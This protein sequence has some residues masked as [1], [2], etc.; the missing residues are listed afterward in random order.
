M[1][2]KIPPDAIP[3]YA[4]RLHNPAIAQFN[5]IESGQIRQFPR[6]SRLIR[7]YPAA[8]YFPF[9]EHWTP[10]PSFRLFRN[11]QHIPGSF[12]N[13]QPLQISVLPPGTD[14]TKSSLIKPNQGK[15]NQ[16]AAF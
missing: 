15:S 11:I 5:T 13:I 3:M 7:E 10:L 8:K 14:Q 4:A 16:M 9:N 6:S 2:A 12:R 1:S